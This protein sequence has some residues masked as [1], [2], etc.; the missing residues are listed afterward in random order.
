MKVQGTLFNWVVSPFPW[1]GCS[2]GVV[3]SGGGVKLT[4][5]GGD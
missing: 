5:N 1:L 3:F 4:W 2:F